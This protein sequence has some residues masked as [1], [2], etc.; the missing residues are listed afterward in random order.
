MAMPIPMPKGM[1][2]LPGLVGL[3]PPVAP[4]LPGA[5]RRSGELAR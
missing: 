2:M 4:F 1:I 5:R 3:L